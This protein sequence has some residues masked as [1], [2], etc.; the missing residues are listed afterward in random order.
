[1]EIQMECHVHPE[2]QT[3]HL[4]QNNVW[5][6]VTMGNIKP[7]LNYHSSAWAQVTLRPFKADQF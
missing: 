5:Y 7:L 2:T 6:T 4:Q 3:Q 1:M